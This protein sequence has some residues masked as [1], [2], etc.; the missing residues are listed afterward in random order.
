MHAQGPRE[1]RVTVKEPNASKLIIQPFNTTCGVRS[2]RPLESHGPSQVF[3]LTN[4]SSVEL[5]RNYTLKRSVLIYNYSYLVFI[6]WY[7]APRTL[8]HR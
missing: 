2:T 8:S 6:T 4:A 1:K 3:K 5:L 7:H